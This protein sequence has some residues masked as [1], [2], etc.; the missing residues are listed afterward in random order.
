MSGTVSSRSIDA[1]EGQQTA[2]PRQIVIIGGGLTGLA[3]AYYV[4]QQA[5]A[6]KTPVNIHLVEASSR[7]GGLVGTE[8]IRG[9]MVDTGADSFITNKPAGVKLC[10]ELGLEDQL[11]S[12]AK[13]FRGALVLHQGKPVPVPEGFT[14]LSPSAIW[15][16]IKTPI[17]TTYGK[18]RL[19]SELF[20]P[21]KRI[22]GDESLASFVRR[23]F[24][25]E[26]LERL[27]QPLV[28]G[29]YTSDPEKLSLMATMPRFLDD[30]QRYGSLIEAARQQALQASAG[31]RNTSGARY[32]LFAAL[33]GGLQQLV[34]RLSH[35]IASYVNIR[36]QSSV[37][38]IEK[39]VGR[40]RYH[41]TL[42]DSSQLD[43][44]G[45]IV[46]APAHKAASLLAWLDADLANELR[47]IEHA[48]SAIVVT[49]HLAENITH[50]LSA[51]GLVIPAIE[52]R[53]ILA[54]SFASRKFPDRAP[55]GQVQLRTFVGGAMQPELFDQTDEQLIQLVKEELAETLGVHGEPLFARVVRYPKAMPQY[56]LGHVDRVNRIETAIARHPGLV[57]AGNAYHG[58]GVPDCIHSGQ[59]AALNLLEQFGHAEPQ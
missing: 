10:Q 53:R 21:R 38:K 49:G 27:V 54:V 13:Q 47:A 36:L 22:P 39:D 32:G 18:L 24:G 34:D 30:E 25:Q 35:T 59:S 9:H 50:P 28:G 55:P 1:A 23:R 48:S 19:L 4:H 56:H 46:T 3:T 11:I 43:A 17:F 7:L 41:V 45:I 8:W 15:P 26:A 5:I 40:Q 52:Q 20:V 12:T 42:A 37:T 2:T 6:A 57:L 33:R 16:I 51:F 44:D 58:V 31:D 14:L 29:I